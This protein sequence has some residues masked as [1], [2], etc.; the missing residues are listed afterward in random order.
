MI[1]EWRREQNHNSK[2][3][4][5]LQNRYALSLSHLNC[6]ILAGKVPGWA[7]GDNRL[8]ICL[9][10]Q[11]NTKYFKTFLLSQLGEAELY[12]STLSL[13]PFWVALPAAVLLLWGSFDLS[14][15]SSLVVTVSLFLPFW[16]ATYE[17][18]FAVARFSAA[19]IPWILKRQQKKLQPTRTQS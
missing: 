1:L 9:P 12:L 4:V 11:K 6:H 17:K 7:G 13:G 15:S 2:T 16:W 5:Y 14:F 18:P 3:Y 19:Y 10:F 8:Q